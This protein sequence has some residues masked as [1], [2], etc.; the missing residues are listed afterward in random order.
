[1]KKNKE[2]RSFNHFSSD[3]NRG[4]LSWLMKREYGLATYL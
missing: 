4:F 3:E 1:M 2:L